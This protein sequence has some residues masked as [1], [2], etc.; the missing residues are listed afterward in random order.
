MHL[1]PIKANSHFLDNKIASENSEVLVNHGKAE[2]SNVYFLENKYP[3]IIIK[4]YVKYYQ[5]IFHSSVA[6]KCV[7]ER[8]NHACLQ[9][10]QVQLLEGPYLMECQCEKKRAR[11]NAT[12]IIGWEDG[13]FPSSFPRHFPRVFPVGSRTK[14]PCRL[15]LMWGCTVTLTYPH[16]LHKAL[17]QKE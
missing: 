9:P 4:S 3:V 11:T 6:S 5:L 14:D 15:D 7:Q 17:W 13:S 10:C 16:V 8:S 12:T 1:E 2:L